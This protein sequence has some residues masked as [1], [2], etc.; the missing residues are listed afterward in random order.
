MVLQRSMLAELTSVKPRLEKSIKRLVLARKAAL[1]DEQLQR[2]WTTRVTCLTPC[3]E[4]MSIR[5]SMCAF[6]YAYTQVSGCCATCQ[7]V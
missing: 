7:R 6:T 4:N 2:K 3:V 1:S 5:M